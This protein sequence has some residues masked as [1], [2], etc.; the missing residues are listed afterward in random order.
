MFSKIPE[1]TG[2]KGSMRKSL[3]AAAFVCA[4]LSSV[5]SF[6]QSSAGTLDSRK[7]YITSFFDCSVYWNS[8][9]IGTLRNGT[10]AEILRS[11]KKWILVRY[12]SGGR[13]IT[14]WIRR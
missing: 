13:Y 1:R 2:R 6:A 10:R 7:I 14:G 9:R 3:V 5:G 11:T 12:W 4:L 8:R